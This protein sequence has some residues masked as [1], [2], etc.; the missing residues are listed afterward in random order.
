[1]CNS[2]DSTD[3]SP[4]MGF[5]SQEY[6]S[7]LP[8]PLPGDL[9]HPDIEPQSPAFAGG[10]FTAEPSGKL[11]R[12]ILGFA[13]DEPLHQAD[14]ALIRPHGP[15]QPLSCLSDPLLQ[16]SLGMAMLSSIPILAG[17]AEAV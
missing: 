11:I 16:G 5:P 13:D 10:F 12:T 14:W 4:S 6:W 3:C 7:G 15:F 1:M 2:C 9:L 17:P 8:C